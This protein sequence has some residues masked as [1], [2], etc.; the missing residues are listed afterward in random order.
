MTCL[1]KDENLKKKNPKKTNNN[2][3]VKNYPVEKD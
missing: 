3:K 1:S 2:K